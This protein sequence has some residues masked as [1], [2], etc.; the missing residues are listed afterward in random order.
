MHIFAQERR[1]FLPKNAAGSGM[2]DRALKTSF[3]GVFVQ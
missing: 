3:F 2:G 1:M